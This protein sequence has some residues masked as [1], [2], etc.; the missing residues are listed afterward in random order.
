[1]NKIRSIEDIKSGY[2]VRLRNGKLYMC[3]RYDEDKFL[4]CFVDKDGYW[5]DAYMAYDKLYNK[6]KQCYD[7]VEVYGLPNYPSRYR[8][9]SKS[10]RPLLYMEKKKMTVHEIEEKLGYKI[11]IVSDK[12]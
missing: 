8:D 2:V 10:Q 11:E 5:I 1:M 7:I 9:I 4:K 12:V 3:M 6:L